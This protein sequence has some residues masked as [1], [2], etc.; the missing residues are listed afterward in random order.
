MLV[1]EFAKRFRL[2][3]VEENRLRKLLG[4]IAKEIDLLRNAGK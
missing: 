1:S 4:P 2:G 3:Q